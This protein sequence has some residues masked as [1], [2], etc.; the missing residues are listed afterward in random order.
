MSTPESFSRSRM[1]FRE[2]KLAGGGDDVAMKFEGYGSVF[3]NVDSYGDVITPGAFKRTLREAKKSDVWPSMLLQ[4][5]GGFFS[6]NAED[7]TPIGIWTELVED[8]HGLKVSGTIAN[9]Q[10]GRDIYELLKMDPRPAIDGL[11][12]GYIPRKYEIPKDSVDG[13]RRK[14]TDIDLLEVSLVTFPAN[15]AARVE[16]V[17]G[18]DGITTVRELEA[19]A[20]DVLGLA[21]PVATA[22]VARVKSVCRRDGEPTIDETVS[23]IQRTIAIFKS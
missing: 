23:A 16:A 19:W 7:M 11:S 1:L 8:D 9:T 14:L 4:H 15:G 10:R 6:A 22:F 2:I 18:W 12:I 17:K 5:G 21:P 13:V 3:N 20:R